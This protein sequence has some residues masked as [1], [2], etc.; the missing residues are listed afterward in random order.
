MHIC[1][2]QMYPLQMIKDVWNTAKPKD[3]T[4]C[5]M[6]IYQGPPPPIHH[7]SMKYHYMKYV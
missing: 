5:R 3:F 4:Y 7:R 6:H 1:L 2:E